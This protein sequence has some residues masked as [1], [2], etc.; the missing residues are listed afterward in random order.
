MTGSEAVPAGEAKTLKAL[1]L[2][3][4][5]R[6][7]DLFVAPDEAGPLTNYTDEAR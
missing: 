3:N 7:Y 2:V 4:M 5:K 1:M 6:S